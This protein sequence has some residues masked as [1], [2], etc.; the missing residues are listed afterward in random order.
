[1]TYLLLSTGTDLTFMI[2]D[3]G[4]DAGSTGIKGE[5]VWHR[6]LF[7]K[8]QDEEESDQF[9]SRWMIMSLKEVTNPNILDRFRRV[10]DQTEEPSLLYL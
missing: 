6:L 5:D 1:L 7:G 8:G 2:E 4:S 3:H 10:D 9:N